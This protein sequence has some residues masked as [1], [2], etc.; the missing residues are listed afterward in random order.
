ML[1]STC[2]N[3]KIHTRFTVVYNTMS[4]RFTNACVCSGN[5]N[6]QDSNRVTRKRV[7]ILPHFACYQTHIV[8]SPV[9]PD[10]YIL[11][12]EMH[13]SPIYRK[14]IL[15]RGHTTKA[16]Q[17][18]CFRSCSDIC[19]F[20]SRASF[21]V[22]V[23]TCRKKI[24]ILPSFRVRCRINLWHNLRDAKLTALIWHCSDC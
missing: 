14:I 17:V 22:K 6:R 3:A 24:S 9:H 19:T 23:Y 1:P 7:V 21:F 8:S 16:D 12:K 10:Y 4:L 5:K 13:L 2:W 18:Q 11:K 15:I 20:V